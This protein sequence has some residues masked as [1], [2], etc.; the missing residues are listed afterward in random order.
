VVS[1]S[2]KGVDNIN[3]ITLCQARLLLMWVTIHG[4]IVSVYN[5]P[6][7]PIQS[8][9]LSNSNSNRNGRSEDH[10]SGLTAG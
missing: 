7:R 4:Y 3:K 9:T 2:G 6:F 8:P 10:F 5:K 1:P